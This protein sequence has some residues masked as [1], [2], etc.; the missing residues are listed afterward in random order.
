MIRRM[1]MDHENALFAASSFS[2]TMMM[3]V[4]E[5]SRNLKIGLLV[6]LLLHTILLWIVLPGMNDR[7]VLKPEKEEPVRV[8]FMPPPKEKFKDLE[9]EIHALLLH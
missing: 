6:A 1:E 5:D 4:L 8:W 3:E 2:E 7:N 9:L